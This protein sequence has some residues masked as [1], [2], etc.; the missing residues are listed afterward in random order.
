MGGGLLG[1]G[2]REGGSGLVGLLEQLASQASDHAAVAGIGALA[3]AVLALGLLE[4]LV[5]VV[6][7][8]LGELLG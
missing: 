5:V 6:G 8:A 1:W 4:E 7:D 3:V 2:E